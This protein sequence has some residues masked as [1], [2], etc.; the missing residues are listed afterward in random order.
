MT[1]WCCLVWSM[2]SIFMFCIISWHEKIYFSW[3]IGRATQCTESKWHPE[4]TIEDTSLL[5]AHDWIVYDALHEILIDVVH[6]HSIL[7]FT[8]TFISCLIGKC[9]LY[10]S[11]IQTSPTY[12]LQ[13][14]IFITLPHVMPTQT[15]LESSLCTWFP[16]S[17]IYMHSHVWWR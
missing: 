11:I 16:G 1:L 2:W 14:H 7:Y 15:K 5:P 13:L 8:D 17:S 6:T 3:N 9:I 12:F 4:Q 10:H